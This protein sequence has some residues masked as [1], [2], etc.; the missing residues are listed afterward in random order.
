MSTRTL[1]LLAGCVLLITF[2]LGLY[3]DYAERGAFTTFVT[4]RFFREP[5]D[6]RSYQEPTQNTDPAQ[7]PSP[8]QVR[9][10]VTSFSN[11]MLSM[12]IGEETETILI[13][14]DTAAY[15]Y[16]NFLTT[17]DGR[18]IAYDQVFLDF[19]RYQPDTRQ[20]AQ[21]ENRIFVE[22]LD[23]VLT[24]DRKITLLVRDDGKSHKTAQAVIVFG[25]VETK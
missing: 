22:R 17:Q 11:R 15:C 6:P 20:T 3:I 18:T 12:R 1:V 21:N 13:V 2:G 7:S 24:K 9:G 5:P 10:Q 8:V 16:P 25:C 23:T 19:S 4:D 14:D